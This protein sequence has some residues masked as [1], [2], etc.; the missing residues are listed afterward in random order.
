MKIPKSSFSVDSSKGMAIFL[1]KLI[2]GDLIEIGSDQVRNLFEEPGGMF[3][4]VLASVLNTCADDI[5][6]KI[7]EA[8]NAPS[9]VDEIFM[10]EDT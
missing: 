5:A 3:W 7:L 4:E 10:L 9:P 8:I 1:E 6:N 2:L